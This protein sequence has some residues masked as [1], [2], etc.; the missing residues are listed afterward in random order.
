MKPFAKYLIILSILFILL[1]LCSNTGMTEYYKRN[2]RARR[3]NKARGRGAR[4]RRQNKRRLPGYRAYRV[5]KSAKCA[6]RAV[7]DPKNPGGTQTVSGVCY[8]EINNKALS[9]TQREHLEE[10]VRRLIQPAKLDTDKLWYDKAKSNNIVHSMALTNAQHPKGSNH[11]LDKAWG[12]LLM[13]QNKRKNVRT[14]LR[15]SVKRR[16]FQRPKHRRHR[17]GRRRRRR[18]RR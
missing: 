1:S 18:Y 3:G 11:P 14:R 16:R 2:R 10:D 7:P 17:G 4:R 12:K 6:T 13:R 8:L 5:L 9:P 15:K